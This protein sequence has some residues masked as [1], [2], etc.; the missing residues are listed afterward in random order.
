L[1]QLIKGYKGTVHQFC[2]SSSS[3]ICSIQK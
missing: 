3:T 2:F 1:P